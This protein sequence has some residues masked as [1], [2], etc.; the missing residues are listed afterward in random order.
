MNEKPSTGAEEARRKLYHEYMISFGVL[1][2]NRIIVSRRF[3]QGV[4]L[5]IYT[6]NSP[7]IK[8]VASF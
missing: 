8:N 3:L 1:K 2:V 6:R 4:R 5:V 7:I